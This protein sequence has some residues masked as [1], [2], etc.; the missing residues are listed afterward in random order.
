MTINFHNLIFY[1]P[2]AFA[3]CITSAGF[4]AMYATLASRDVVKAFFSL[5]TFSL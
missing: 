1:T 4:I 2:V 3:F 5:I